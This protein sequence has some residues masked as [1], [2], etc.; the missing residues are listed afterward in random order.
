LER[1]FSA[2]YTEAGNAN[3]QKAKNDWALW[4]YC[5]IC[6]EATYIP[7]NSDAHKVIIEYMKAYGWGHPQCHE[8]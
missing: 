7:P 5:N 6:G 4:H 2:A 3:Y 8:Q 1:D